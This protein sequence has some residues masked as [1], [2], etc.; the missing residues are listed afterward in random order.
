MPERAGDRPVIGI[1]DED[2]LAVGIA[3]EG[4]LVVTG[5]FRSGKTTAIKTI[6]QSVARSTENVDTV[7]ISPKTFSELH[8]FGNWTS[9]ALGA[10]DVEPFA[11]ELVVSL[12][13]GKG[14]W[15]KKGALGFIVVESAGD[16]EG[17]TAEGAVAALIKAARKANV[18][19]VVETDLATG[20]AAWQI[21][22]E[23]KTARAGIVLQPEE[24][25]GV[26]LF[27]VSFPRGTRSEFPEGR[28][29][30][31][32]AGRAIKVQIAL[33]DQPPARTTRP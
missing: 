14:S 25:D 24:T 15:P 9:T 30:L 28:G 23:L 13:D 8:E 19:I 3:P 12:S 18:L 31:V 7:L 4:L 20:P 29:Y 11:R 32:E 26:S 2:L 6:I 10:V 27:R 22:S 16:F 21:Y 1:A 17:S 33:P 5:P